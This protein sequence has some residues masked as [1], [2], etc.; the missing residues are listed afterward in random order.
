VIPNIF[1]LFQVSVKEEEISE[2][3]NDYEDLFQDAENTED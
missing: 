3:L 1:I 2:N